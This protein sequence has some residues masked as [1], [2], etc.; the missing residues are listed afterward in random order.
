ML[1]KDDIT[2]HIKANELPDDNKA[3]SNFAQHESAPKIEL[4][5]D[6]DIISAIQIK[7]VCGKTIN[8][9][10]E[11]NEELQSLI[12]NNNRD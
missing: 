5:K 10:L 6:G 7:C 1:K 9:D 2:D 12:Y 4:V 8:I 3:I 11:Y